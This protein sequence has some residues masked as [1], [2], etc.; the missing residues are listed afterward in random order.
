[1]ALTLGLFLAACG[2]DSKND[3]SNSTAAGA[4]GATTSAG[5]DAVKAKLLSIADMPAGFTKGS[6]DS[7]NGDADPNKDTSAD[8]EFCKQLAEVAK[9]YKT[10]GEAS[11]E[12]QTQAG[13]AGASFF[14]EQLS[15]FSS[16]S[17]A[18]KAFALF[19]KALT[20][21]CKDL[22]DAERGLKGTFAALSFPKI[23]D[24]TFAVALDATQTNGAQSTALKGQLVTIRKG[25]V[26]GLLFNFGFGTDSLS[27]SQVE[28]LARKAADK[29]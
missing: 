25:D 16:A 2:G 27:I 21:E 13:G 6:E 22:T 18:Q 26:L 12:F 29:L 19:R 4:A 28:A 14:N 17:D 15:R 20:D 1:M 9:Q 3:A 5:G 7:N 11:I 10:D 23:A 8:D 24:D